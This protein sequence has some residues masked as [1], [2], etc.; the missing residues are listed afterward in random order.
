MYYIISRAFI[1][2]PSIIIFY[3]FPLIL[4]KNNPPPVT[5][6]IILIPSTPTYVF[7]YS[8]FLKEVIAPLNASIILLY[9]IL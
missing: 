5:K 6:I 1:N 3:S 2:I 7:T 9:I 4:F 8:S